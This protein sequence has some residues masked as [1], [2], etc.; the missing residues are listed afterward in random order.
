MRS[1]GDTTHA[2]VEPEADA[3]SYIVMRSLGLPSKVGRA[4]M[5]ALKVSAR[6]R[7][8][9]IPDQTYPQGRARLGARLRR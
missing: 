1:R 9:P 2:Q 8:F 6:R 7:V 3:T 5:G 4:E